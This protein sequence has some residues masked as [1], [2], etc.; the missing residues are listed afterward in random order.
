MS[1]PHDPVEDSVDEAS[2]QQ[3]GRG[4]PMFDQL[5]SELRKAITAVAPDKK[6]RTAIVRILARDFKRDK[7]KKELIRDAQVDAIADDLKAFAND[8]DLIL[9]MFV[10]SPKTG[11]PFIAC[12]RDRLSHSYSQRLGYPTTRSLNDDRLHDLRQWI[13]AGDPRRKPDDSRYPLQWVREAVICLAN[14]PDPS[15]R[16]HALNDLLEAIDLETSSRGRECDDIAFPYVKLLASHLAAGRIEQILRM[17]PLRLPDVRRQQEIKELARL[18]DVARATAQEKQLE[19]ESQR[20]ELSTRATA[21]AERV[22]F[23]DIQLAEALKIAEETRQAAS[24]R[25]QH[26]THGWQQQVTHQ[27]HSLKRRLSHELDEAILCLDRKEP[28]TEMALDRIRNAEL[29]I[30]EME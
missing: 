25:E 23:L 21:L 28:N 24:D 11:R 10:A 12:I 26:L 3:T 2:E 5:R 7:K 15:I 29:I 17:R 14:E 22:E 4:K 30:R 13:H 16:L 20:D 6:R 1:D 27:R 8:T 9:E 18:S 19:A